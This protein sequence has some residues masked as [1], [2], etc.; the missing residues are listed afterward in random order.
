MGRSSKS[1]LPRVLLVILIVL[2]AGA[3]AVLAWL[4]A[5][6][7]SAAE[8]SQLFSPA[9]TEVPATAEPTASP[10]PVPTPTA[11]PKPTAE[12]SPTPVPVELTETGDAGQEYIDKFV[13][14]GDSTTYGLGAYGI[15]PFT[16]IWADSIGTLALFNWEID[17]I[18]YY[19]PADPYN[20]QSLS[21]PDCAARRQP[22]YLMI[23]LGINGIAFLDED[24]FKDYY[25]R[26]IQAIQQASPDTKIICQSIYPVIDSYVPNGISNEKVN[27]ANRWVYDIAA[28]TGVRYLNSH[29][30]LMDGSGQL[31]GDYTDDTA[32]GIHLNAAGFS[33][34]LENIRTH[35]YQ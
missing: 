3:A 23:T 7:D 33:V 32:M 5:A 24:G 1:R 35:A 8:A 13:F 6:P 11:T 15:L 30:V 26:M 34:L 2:I 16:Q 28:Q 29:D 19:D 20:A 12:P 4:L 25:V 9:A 18:A 21:I 27:A 22:E 31:N 10:T 14:L 17:P